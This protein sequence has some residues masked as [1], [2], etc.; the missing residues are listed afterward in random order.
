MIE[1]GR[2][3]SFLLATNLLATSLLATMVLLGGWGCQTHEFA[4]EN[5]IDTGTEPGTDSVDTGTNGDGDSD[6]NVQPD[7][8]PGLAGQYFTR[9]NLTDFFLCQHDPVIQFDWSDT[10]PVGLDPSA[11][12]SVRWQGWVTPDHSG[13][14]T[15]STESDDGMR[16]WVDGALIIDEWYLKGGI[17]GEGEI[18]LTQGEPVS[19]VVEF[20]SAPANS[21]I[22]LYWEHASQEVEIIPTENLH[23]VACEIPEEEAPALIVDE[24]CLQPDDFDDSVLNSVWQANGLQPTKGF[25]VVED[26]SV[27]IMVD[28]GYRFRLTLDAGTYL[29]QPVAGDVDFEFLVSAITGH[30]TSEMGLMIRENWESD[31]PMAFIGFTTIN[32]V[33]FVSRNGTNI[34]ADSIISNSDSIVIPSF[35]YWLRLRYSA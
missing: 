22:A 32:E 12:M 28:S 3:L 14:Y 27:S 13:T 34:P 5:H 15:F 35:P 8:F 31:G 26:G 23:S 11:A 16:L 33:H 18:D 17:T 2:R 29:A 4:I 19:I 6:T 1:A 30:R 9:F 24:P 21:R 10:A 25:D 7:T 20:F